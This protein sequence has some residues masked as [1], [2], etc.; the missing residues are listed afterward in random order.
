MTIT[1]AAPILV[2][3]D[4]PQNLA[5]LRQILSP[6]FKLIFAINGQDALDAANKLTPA[7]VLLDIN[8][9][10]MSGYAVCEA[11]K[12]NPATENVPVIF[13]TTL[14]EAGNESKGFAAGAVDY[15]VK[16]VNPDIVRARVRSQLSRVWAEQLEA[17]YQDAIWMLGEAGHFSD[18][19]TADH[20]WRMASYARAIAEGMG[21]APDLCR[22]IELAAPLHDTGKIGIPSAILRKPGPLDDE[23]WQVMRT[24][25]HIGWKILSRSSAQVFEMAAEIAMAHH[26]K[27]DG[28]GYPKRLAADAIPLA[29]RIVA[30][31]DV[32]D[33][34]STKRPYKQPWPYEKC[35]A[36]IRDEAGTHFDPKVV[37][38]FLNIQPRIL[39]LK[40][41]WD[42][43]SAAP[44]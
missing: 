17:S 40:D 39:A 24:H 38:V 20:V 14:A 21:L 11:L 12:K 42:R 41:K 18:A 4:E 35:L 27:W 29:A 30:V 37:E 5:L 32:F 2:V 16:P 43:K 7:M 31:A 23:E 19:D 36:L 44:T 8:M 33:A 15:I 13:V 1:N 22:R 25:P 28:S 10:D 9:P 26:E 6:E 3:D 34:L